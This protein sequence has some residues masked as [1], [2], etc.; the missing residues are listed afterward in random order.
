MADDHGDLQ[1]PRAGPPERTPAK[2]KNAL[3]EQTRHFVRSLPPARTEREWLV[4]RLAGRFRGIAS[5]RGQI[6]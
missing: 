1:S 4:A 3:A 6:I 5:E 2:D